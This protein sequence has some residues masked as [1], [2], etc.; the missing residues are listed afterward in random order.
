MTNRVA[1]DNRFT[2]EHDPFGKLVLIDSAGVRHVGITPVRAFPISDPQKGLAL[3]NAEGHEVAWIEDLATLFP[4]V[5]V[6]IESEL[7]HREFLPHI[8][9]ILSVSMVTDPCE[10][11]VET[12]RGPTTFLLKSEEDVRRLDANRA[13]VVD[14]HGVHYLIDNAERMDRKS[15]RI[16]ER[17]L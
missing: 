2:L 7:M 8:R 13:I 4:D 10:W 15:R 6:A 17:Y 14:A 3:M 12:D 1:T 11:E 5:R 9:R 16:L